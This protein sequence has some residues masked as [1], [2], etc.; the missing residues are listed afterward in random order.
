[1]R[2]SEFCGGMSIVFG[3]YSTV[4]RKKIF[5]SPSKR[6]SIQ[7]ILFLMLAQ[8]GLTPMGILFAYRN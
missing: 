6:D 3:T 2:Y 4:V 1:M 7:L 8:T 5:R